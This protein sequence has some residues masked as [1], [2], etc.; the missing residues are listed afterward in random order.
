MTIVCGD[1]VVNASI[2]PLLYSDTP[3]PQLQYV[4][5][6]LQPHVL[7][8]MQQLPRAIFDQDS[9][10]PHTARVSHDCLRNV[11]TLPW[12]ARSS[13]LSLIEHIWDGELDI[14]RV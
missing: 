3:L 9:A 8:L 5:G 12:P 13:D 1:P 10:R 7:P 4:H 11:T 2:L 14:P 6:I